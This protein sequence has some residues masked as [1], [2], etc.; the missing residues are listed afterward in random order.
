MADTHKRIELVA[1]VAIILLAVVLGVILIDRYFSAQDKPTPPPS[2]VA[3]SLTPGMEFPLKSLDLAKKEKTLVMVLST[4]CRYCT[5]S[6]PFYKDLVEK[7]GE[8]GSVNMVAVFPE[9]LSESGKYLS[10]NNVR[11]DEVLQADPSE[12]LARGTPTLI[13]TNDKGIV[14]DVWIGKLPK[15]KEEEVLERVFSNVVVTNN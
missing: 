12:L 13:L 1:N 7:N 5:A 3:S 10:E 15:E 11:F 2:T 14:L 8:N 6:L 9:E 4:T